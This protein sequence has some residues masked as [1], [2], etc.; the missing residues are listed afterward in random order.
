MVE[1]NNRNEPPP[2]LACELSGAAGRWQRIFSAAWRGAWAAG[3]SE[4]AMK[5]L[6]E[7]SMAR[8]A[9]IRLTVAYKRRGRAFVQWFDGEVARLVAA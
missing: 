2:A 8:A 9:A 6:F 7:R 3:L 5:K 1:W 4:A